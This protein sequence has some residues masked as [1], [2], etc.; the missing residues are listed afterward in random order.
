MR[1]V[2]HPSLDLDTVASLAVLGAAPADVAFVPSAAV[3]PDPD[4]WVVDH[5]VGEKGR[6]DDDGIRHGAVLSVPEAADL[7][8][9]DLLAEVD[10]QNAT[11]KAGRGIPWPR[12]WAAWGPSS[13]TRS[14]RPESAVEVGA[15][16]ARGCSSGGA[17]QTS[18]WRESGGKRVE[19]GQGIGS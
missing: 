16:E 5:P 8:G 14:V 1:Y 2:T 12:S 17:G 13:A 7:D 3:T 10:E 18:G 15:M 11:A 9:S 6:L 4:V 19:G